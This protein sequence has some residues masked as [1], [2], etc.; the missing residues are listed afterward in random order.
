MSK[1]KQGG[2][3][4]SEGSA[5]QG[6]ELKFRLVKKQNRMIIIGREAQKYLPGKT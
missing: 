5:A 6:L 3:S 2:L 1:T 4:D